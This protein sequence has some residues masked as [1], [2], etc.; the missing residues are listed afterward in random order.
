MTRVNLIIQRRGIKGN[1]LVCPLTVT[2]AILSDT[3]LGR[4]RKMGAP[5]VSA[6]VMMT[7]TIRTNVIVRTA[8]TGGLYDLQRLP[9]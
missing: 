6:L 9:I 7:T 2:S 8:L 1:A 5:I 3:F 4:W